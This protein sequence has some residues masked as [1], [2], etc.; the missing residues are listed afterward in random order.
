[1]AKSHPERP[2]GASGQADGWG[3]GMRVWV[4]RAGKA[5]LGPGRLDLL[6]SIG[7][8]HSIS[9]AARNWACLTA[10]PGNW[11]RASTRRP[12]SRSLRQ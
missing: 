3:V 8:C 1:M 4:E 9:A 10:T 7:R 5:I 6:D 12:A 11:S 2:D